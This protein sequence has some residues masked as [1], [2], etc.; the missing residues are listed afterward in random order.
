MNPVPKVKLT[1]LVDALEW[2]SA[3][4]PF[5]SAAYVDRRTGQIHY[6]GGDVDFEDEPSSDLTDES[7]YASVPHKRDLDL[8]R[9]L[10]SSFAESQAPEL[11][12]EVHD[13][14]SRRGAYGRFKDLLDRRGLLQAWY[15]Y[16]QKA[17]EEAI[18][19][20]AEDEGFEVS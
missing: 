15:D 10:A 12:D 8:G 6:E 7:L 14:F 17:V 5:D 1:D 19:Q 18:R 4:G 13:C 11:S 16:E 9:R 20:W 3:D 2:S